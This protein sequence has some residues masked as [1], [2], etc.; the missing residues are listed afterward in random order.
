MTIG[1]TYFPKLVSAAAYENFLLDWNR[2]A[3][4]QLTQAPRYST[5]RLIYLSPSALEYETPAVKSGIA[6][7]VAHKNSPFVQ[8]GIISITGKYLSSDNEDDRII[9]FINVNLPPEFSY[10][11]PFILAAA[12]PCMLGEGAT[13]CPLQNGVVYNQ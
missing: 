4:D 11:T 1:R 5:D 6:Q 7:W 3:H 13:S 10:L 8:Y 9:I 12:R 2:Y